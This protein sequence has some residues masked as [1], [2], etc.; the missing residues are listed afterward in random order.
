LHYP[1][2]FLEAINKGDIA[3][4]L[5]Y[6]REPD[7]RIDSLSSQL[8]INNHNPDCWILYRPVFSSE[9]KNERKTNV[10]KKCFF[11][12]L[13]FVLLPMMAFAGKPQPPEPVVAPTVLM[14][15][16]GGMATIEP[17]DRDGT[18]RTVFE[19]PCSEASPDFIHVS[20]TTRGYGGTA[21]FS[22]EGIVSFADNNPAS[23]DNNSPEAERS[24]IPLNWHWGYNVA[25]T[26]EFDA[27][28]RQLSDTACAFWKIKAA[29]NPD[30]V[31]VTVLYNYTITYPQK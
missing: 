25:Q 4:Y 17:A 24:L 30:T 6:N 15:T 29:A 19:Y 23:Y 5:I 7:D 11:V 31:P 10:M 27:A 9:P 16:G 18:Y 13:I 20:L 26:V 21:G 1:V 14:V 12:I 2:R 3:S 28:K 22:F 8:A